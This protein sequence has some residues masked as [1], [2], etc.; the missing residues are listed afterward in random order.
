MTEGTFFGKTVHCTTLQ[1]A[2]N[3]RTPKMQLSDFYLRDQKKKPSR[4]I[5]V[6][7]SGKTVYCMVLQIG[8]NE[9]TPKNAGGSAFLFLCNG[10]L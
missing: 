3:E 6:T 1:M 8:P 10:T 7:F 5:V 9:R 4:M 2:P